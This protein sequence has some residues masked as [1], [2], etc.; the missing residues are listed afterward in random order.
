MKH[1]HNY[2]ITEKDFLLANQKA[3]L[4]GG[5]SRSREADHL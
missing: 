4:G 1:L 5:D 3:I 2:K